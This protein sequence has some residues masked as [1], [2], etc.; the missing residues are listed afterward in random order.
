MTQP[1]QSTPS[2][3]GRVLAWV[4]GITVAVVVVAAAGVATWIATGLD[5]V[6]DALDREPVPDLSPVVSEAPLPPEAPG[7]EESPRQASASS[8]TEVGYPLDPNR[9]T[10]PSG[11]RFWMLLG[12]DSRDGHRFA[13]SQGHTDRGRSDVMAIVRIRPGEQPQVLSIPRDFR[14]RYPDGG[15]DRINAAYAEG[16]LTKTVRVVADNFGIP[17]EHVALVDFAGF[18]DVVAALGGID[19]C[20]DSAIRDPTSDLDLP[21]GCSHLDG[22]EALALV[23]SRHTESGGDFARIRRQQ[24]VLVA[25]ARKLG[26]AQTILHLADLAASLRGSV[27]VDDTFSTSEAIGLFRS[28]SPLTDTTILRTLPGDPRMIDGKSLVVATADS[29]AVLDAFKTGAGR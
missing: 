9:T 12:S 13:A 26:S 1:A 28:L 23:R 21:S 22:P 20:L 25:F 19:V 14:V 10:P 29:Q 2:R 6:D 4:V 16:G 11:T 3:R 7:A 15:R 18:E 8:A 24:L 17:V 27:T 5:A